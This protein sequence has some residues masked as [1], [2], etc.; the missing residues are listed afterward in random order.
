MTTPTTTECTDKAHAPAPPGKGPCPTCDRPRCNGTSAAG[1]CRKQPI[2]D[3]TVCR[4]HGGSATQVKD[5]AERRRAD[6]QAMTAA[7]S[8]GLPREVDPHTALLEELHRTAGAVQW[9]GA[10]VA[11]LDKDQV[12]WGKVKETRGTQ[13]EKGAENGTTYAAQTNAFV[14]LWQEERD[15]LVKVAK[16][17][18]D[19]GIEERRVRIAESTGQQLAAFA[20][21]LLDR[22]L[23]A[24][25]EAIG[26]ER[27]AELALQTLWAQSALVIVPEEFRRLAGE[28]TPV[29][30]SAGG[31]A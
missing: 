27:A 22:M 9:L 15:R 7:E 14:R 6:R 28:G 24:L 8:F 21:S 16:A 11:D 3:A 10:I 13:L 26:P 17:C 1:R 12:V 19:A 29:A 23:G 30:L 4:T 20:R 18:H 25:V 2:K 31:A 5:A